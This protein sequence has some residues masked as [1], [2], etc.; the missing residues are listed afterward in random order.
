[1]PE[2][3][4]KLKKAWRDGD[5][6]ALAESGLKDMQTDYPKIFE[7]LI[8]S[9]NENWLKHINKL[10]QTP[11]TEALYVGALHLAGDVGLVARLKEM[12]YTVEQL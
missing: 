2:Y 5:L 11:E 7:S 1:M 6:K 10:I 12:G 3:V 4:A 9:R 8:R